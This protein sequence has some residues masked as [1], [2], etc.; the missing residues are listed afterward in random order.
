ALLDAAEAGLGEGALAE[1]AAR[2]L[3]DPRARGMVRDLH[4]Q[5][6]DIDGY[7]NIW[8]TDEERYGEYT[9][10][11]P[12]AMTLE[13][14]A[15][16]D[17]VAYGGGTVEELFSSRTTVVEDRLAATYG[18][19]DV[20]GRDNGNMVEV[21]LDPNE[22]AGLLSLSGWLALQSDAFTEDLIHRGA[23]V[24][25][26]VLCTKVPSP[27]MAVPPLPVNDE[28]RT[29]RE[30]IADHTETC[31]GGCHTDYI[32]PIGFAF[33][34][35][36]AF[37]AF[38]LYD[39]RERRIDSSGTYVFEDGEASWETGVDFLEALAVNPQVHR[40][41]VEH[42][43]TY[44]EGRRMTLVDEARIDAYTQQSLDGAPIIDLIAAMVTDPDFRS[45]P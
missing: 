31:G 23:F 34:N 17:R 45:R 28:E 4:R 8:R 14:Y 37:G 3:D 26:A 43:L 41:Y 1:H 39:D 13:V 38:R 18:L 35:Y 40:C 29:L 20:V 6:L 24:N 36:D 11:T 2:M 16:V 19:E 9:A 10:S 7:E 32:N 21:Q 25:D 30:L 22:R 12:Y 42:L 15:Y 33:A 5:W 27:G 44:T